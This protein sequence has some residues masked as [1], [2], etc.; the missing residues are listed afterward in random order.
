[1]IVTKRRHNCMEQIQLG[2]LLGSARSPITIGFLEPSW[3]ARPP[4]TD[5]ITVGHTCFLKK[6]LFAN[7][8]G[9]FLARYRIWLEFF[10]MTNPG[11]V[12]PDHWTWAAKSW[13]W[14]SKSWIWKPNPGFGYP[15][16]V[17]GRPHPG[18]GRPNPGFEGQNQRF[19]RPNP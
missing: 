14:M 16:P 18:F 8:G 7:R 1:M 12:Y 2:Y 3:S 10:T 13:I 17:L 4:I 6:I 19:G 9:I 11:P 5:H 15:N